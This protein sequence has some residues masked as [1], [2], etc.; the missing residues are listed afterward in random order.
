MIQA[1]RDSEVCIAV[2]TSFSRTINFQVSFQF[3]ILLKI[4]LS[5]SR[6]EYLFIKNMF[7]WSC[8]FQSL[9]GS[10]TYKEMLQF[11]ISLPAHPPADTFLQGISVDVL[12]S[13]AFIFFLSP[14][15]SKYAFHHKLLKKIFN[16]L[17]HS[18][19]IMIVKWL[20]NALK[21]KQTHKK[22]KLCKRHNLNH[23]C[24]F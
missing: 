17:A 11:F 7:I 12:M 24:P 4:S 13:S 2:S 23:F 5:Y 6:K 22:T 16:V 8:S 15:V 14:W 3:M 10:F 19:V 18:M 21:K 20:L 1:K 9:V